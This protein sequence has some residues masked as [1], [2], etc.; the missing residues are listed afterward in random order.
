MTDGSYWNDGKLNLMASSANGVWAVKGEGS[1]EARLQA[2]GLFG[3]FGA[4]DDGTLQKGVRLTYPRF[5]ENGDGTVTDAMTGL[6]WLKVANCIQGDW[7]TAVAAEQAGERAMRAKGRLESRPVAHAEPAR[8]AEHGG[9]P[10]EQRVGLSEFHVSQSGREQC[11]RRLFSADS[12]ATSFIGH[13]PRTRRMAKRRGRC[14]VATL[15]C[16]TGIRRRRGIRWRYGE[17]DCG[18][19][20]CWNATGGRSLSSRRPYGAPIRFSGLEPHAEARG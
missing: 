20:A 11:F 8:D 18:I 5:I 4:G 1:G 6:T 9:P 12:S 2:T 15:E 19:G 17:D 16:T 7:A 13:R 3:G 10:P 14:S